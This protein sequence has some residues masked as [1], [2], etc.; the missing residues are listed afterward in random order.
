MSEFQCAGCGAAQPVV[1][2]PANWRQIL[3]GGWTCAC[4]L[5]YDRSNRVLNILARASDPLGLTVDHAKLRRLRPDL[6]GVNSLMNTFLEITRGKFPVLPYIIEHVQKGDS[7]AAVVVSIKPLLIAAY[8]DELDCVAL[9]RF[10]DRFQRD[11]ELTVG[12]R[13]LTLNT[14]NQHPDGY[15]ADLIPGENYRPP[16]T[17]FHPI[18]AEFVASETQTIEERKQRILPEE[19]ARTEDLGHAYV[20]ENPGVARDGRPMNAAQSAE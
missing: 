1:R 12:S 10:H 16:W 2:R 13:L 11:Y 9:L 7:R 19:W 4:G 14:Y 15:D 5:D 20:R 18:I 8:T 3:F 6:Y 17:G